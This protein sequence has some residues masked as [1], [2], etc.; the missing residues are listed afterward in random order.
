[1]YYLLGGTC[2]RSC[3]I[4]PS[5]DRLH[6]VVL[7]SEATRRAIEPIFILLPFYIR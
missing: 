6:K 3:Q 2:S 4:E 5:D 7:S 1:M